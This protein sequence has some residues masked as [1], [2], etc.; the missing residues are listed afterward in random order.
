MKAV[1]LAGGLGNR[2]AEETEYGL[3]STF[4]RFGLRRLYDALRDKRALESPWAAG[5]AP[6]HQSGN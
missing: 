4:R 5:D 2:I 1:V 6:W 3:M